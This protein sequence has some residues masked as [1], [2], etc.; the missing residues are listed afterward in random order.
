MIHH[1]TLRLRH[2]RRRTKR[3]ILLSVA[4]LLLYYVIG[5]SAPFVYLRPTGTGS[6]DLSRYTAEETGSER[7]TLIESN[8][9]ALEYRLRLIREAREEIL[10]TTYD[11]KEGS[12]ADAIAAELL[13]AADRGVRVRILVDGLCGVTN[14]EGRTFF[15]ALS[16][17]PNIELRLYNRFN[18][19]LPWKMNG[20]LHDKMFVVDASVYIVGGRNTWDRFLGDYGAKDESNDR[21]LLVLATDPS[22]SDNSVLALKAYFDAL[23]SADATD[24]FRSFGA[25]YHDAKMER[26]RL[27][28]KENAY[29]AFSP[30]IS[31]SSL[32]E[33]LR[34]RTLPTDRIS[35]ITGEIGIYG[36]NPDVWSEMKQLMLTATD[37]V[38]IQS[39]YIVCSRAM[40]R[41]LAEID[42]AVPLV[43]VTNSILN[44]DNKFTPADYLYH[45]DEI[46]G[47]GASIL[48]YNGEKSTHAKTVLIDDSLVLI[49]SF[50]LD[51][52]STYMDTELM[53]VVDSEA[54]GGLV[55]ESMEAYYADC[56]EVAPGTT[57]DAL[58]GKMPFYKRAW[59]YV[60]GLLLQ[61]FRFEL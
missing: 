7:V 12:A 34:A 24:G 39:P 21:E 30:A 53:I 49:G 55:G 26:E 40:Y 38:V 57:V 27:R 29:T 23:W 10:L 18:P 2:R 13:D 31:A 41:D 11:F 37:R 54:L 3:M 60:F 19:L 5:L 59:Y 45:Q 48:E 25:S 20:R 4:L 8:V 15:N 33:W 51:L 28:I 61:P 1:Q 35:L 22:D 6:G 56:T 43:L 9:L 17:H 32:Y 42:Q 46:L 36:K 58:V 44:T 47:S 50:N 16:T 52:R 14:M